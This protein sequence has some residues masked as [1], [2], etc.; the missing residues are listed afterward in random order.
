MCFIKSLKYM[1]LVWMSCFIISCA[2][3]ENTQISNDGDISFENSG[4]A[5]AQSAFLVGVKALHNFQFD[6]ARIAFEEAEKID[7]SFVMAFWGQAM[8]NNMPLWQRQNTSEAKQ[9][10]ERLAST[11]EGRISRAQS[12]KEKAFIS[13]VD[14][15]FFSSD[16]KLKRDLAYSGIMARMHDQWPEDHEISIFYA[17]SLLG[18]MRPGDDGFKKQALAAS[19]AMSVMDENKTHPGAAHFTIH[20]LDDPEHAI[21]ALA[22]AKVY[23]DIAPSSAHALHMPSHIFLQL[24]MWERVVNSNIESYASAVSH[25][26]KLIESGVKNIGTSMVGGE[27]FHSLSWLAYANLMLG[28]YDRAKENLVMAK[29]A[30][31]ANPN[32][33]RAQ[34]G[35]YTMLARH[36]IESADCSD[37]QLGD[38]DSGMGKNAALVAAAGMCA[39]S[40]KNIDLARAAVNRLNAMRLQSEEAGKTYNAMQIQI[41]ELE[42]GALV[43]AASQQFDQAITLAEQAKVLELEN[44]SAP[45]GPPV[46]MKPAAELYAEILAAAGNH[47][48]AINAYKDSLDWVPN[49]TPSIMGLS[50]VAAKNGDAALAEEMRTKLQATPGI[51]INKFVY[52]QNDSQS[53]N[54]G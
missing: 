10:L 6:D 48:A 52:S 4:V 22:A 13:A 7:P 23:A 29:T 35:Y 36:A 1:I 45:S 51:N 17:L 21:L 31:E 12:D 37:V 47:E 18:T 43:A 27:D 50:I 53:D 49:R 3:S 32:N 28:H 2:Q 26:K 42:V 14:A 9:I 34:N 8:S 39:V 40:N 41:I 24:G 15:L 44:M 16:D 25:T 19:I 20:S 5:A 54:A 11:K 46:P 30:M 38:A 33:M